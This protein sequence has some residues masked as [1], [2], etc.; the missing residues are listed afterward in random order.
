MTAPKRK[1]SVSLDSDLVDELE[2]ADEA[3]SS[4][5]NQAIRN[6]LE[7]RRRQRQLR[8]YLD[9]LETLHGPPD[10]KLVDKYTALL[11]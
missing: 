5:V 4:Q 2:A 7:I 11:S 8:R 6:E 9:E 10:Q 3:L 1:V